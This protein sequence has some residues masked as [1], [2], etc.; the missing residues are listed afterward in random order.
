[1][2]PVDGGY[3]DVMQV[4]RSGHVITDL[5]HTYPERGLSH[6]DRCGAVTFDRCPTCGRQLPGAPMCPAWCRS[7]S[8]RRRSIVLSA[9]PC[10]PGPIGRPLRVL[11]IRW[12]SWSRSCA[13]YRWS[14]V[15]CAYRQGD[16][17]PFRVVDE[18]DLEDLLRSLLPLHFDEVR[19]EGR[20][21]SYASAT[22]TDFLPASTGIALTAKRATA[23]SDATRLAEEMHEDVAYYEPHRACRA[24]VVFIYDPEQVLPGPRQLENACS[25]ARE[26]L[27]VRCIIAS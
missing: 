22:R 9:G 21:P 8:C 4:C 12:P 27:V 17:S 15:S 10:F 5:L 7:A 13:G 3:R 20:T 26:E 2:S 18:R 1:M 23:A 24:L 6:C 25:V 16:R 19:L 11:P 14:S